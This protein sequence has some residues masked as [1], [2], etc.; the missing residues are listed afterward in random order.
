MSPSE[1][2]LGNYPGDT[3]CECRG[4]KYFWPTEIR[5]YVGPNQKVRCRSCCKLSL[6]DLFLYW[7]WGYHSNEQIIEKES[8]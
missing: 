3:K 7:R 8:T 1:L 6:I 4:W 5:G 2:K